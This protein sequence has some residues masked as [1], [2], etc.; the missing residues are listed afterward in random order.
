MIKGITNKRN[1]LS[2]LGHMAIIA[3]LE[4]DTRDIEDRI[5]APIMV[6]R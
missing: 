2:S 3:N 5:N 4:I 1:G 6:L